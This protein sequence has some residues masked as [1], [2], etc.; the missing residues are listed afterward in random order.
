MAQIGSRGKGEENCVIYSGSKSGNAGGEA[1]DNATA[2]FYLK[3]PVFFLP[4]LLY[5]VWWW[6]MAPV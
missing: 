2:A 4:L 3:G 1:H 5:T 6:L